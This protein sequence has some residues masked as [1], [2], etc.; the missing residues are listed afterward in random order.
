MIVVKV[1]GSLFDHPALG[2]GLRDFLQTLAPNEVLLVPGGGPVADAV[3][4]TGSRS[5]IG[6]RSRALAGACGRLGV[7]ARVVG[8][9][10]RT[11][12]SPPPCREGGVEPS[13]FHCPQNVSGGF[14]EF[15]PSLQGG[16]RGSGSSRLLRL[17]PRR[18]LPPRCAPSLLECHHGLH[19]GTRRGRVPRRA[20]DTAQIRGRS[21]RHIVGSCRRERLGGC[22]LSPSCPDTGVPR[23]GGQFPP[24][25]RRSRLS[26]RRVLCLARIL[27]ARE[28]T[29]H[30]VHYR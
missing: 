26:E 2:P 25:A 28:L 17:R 27:F 24:Q 21:T 8:D 19:R 6:R 7:T 10:S 4:P 29:R 12:P 22:T 20:P 11:H 14:P 9:A 5:W 30:A 1:G 18:R 13:E 15:T 3:R 16:G 23:R